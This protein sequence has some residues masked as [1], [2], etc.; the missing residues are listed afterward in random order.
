MKIVFF[1]VAAKNYLPSVRLLMRSLEQ[2]HPDYDRYL[3]LMDRPQGKFD[4][5]VEHFSVI[6]AEEM[7]VAALGDMIAQYSLLEMSTALKPFAFQWLFESTD[8]DAVVYLDPDICVYSSFEFLFDSILPHASV[9]LTPHLLTPQLDER[10][11]NDYHMLQ[12]GTF[13]LGFLA[14]SRTSESQTFLRWW[15]QKLEKYCFASFEKNLFTDQRW[16]DLIP[17]FLENFEILRHPGYNVAYWNLNQR[18]V[19]FDPHKGWMVGLEPL[20]FFHFSGFD[21]RRATEISKHQDRLSWSDID[22]VHELFRT[23]AEDV[24]RLGYAE[25]INWPYAFGADSSVGKPSQ[26]ASGDEE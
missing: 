22:N 5:S 16:C 12:A 23:Y 20:V 4:P 9:V 18:G 26:A 11:P 13:N 6:E 17:G 14:V 3:F 24:H 1:T 21:P 8:A 10:T 15:G 25:A 2:Y 7:G 19:E